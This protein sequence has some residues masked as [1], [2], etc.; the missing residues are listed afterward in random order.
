MR[1][2]N[3]GNS[4]ATFY[5]VVFKPGESREV[6]GPIISNNFIRVK[7]PVVK[8]D[9]KPAQQVKLPKARAATTTKP[10]AVTNNQPKV[11]TKEKE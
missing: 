11:E 7:E 10:K 3:C 5:G 9:K 4:S 2:K 6:P 1:Y 8:K